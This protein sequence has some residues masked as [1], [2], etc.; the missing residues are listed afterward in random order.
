MNTCYCLSWGGFERDLLEPPV[1]GIGKQQTPLASAGAAPGPLLPGG[2]TRDRQH[3]VFCLLDWGNGRL[4]SGQPGCI[5]SLSGPDAAS[6]SS[7]R[8]HRLSRDGAGTLPS[9]QSRL[10]GLFLLLRVSC[11]LQP[12]G[13][14]TTGI[15]HIKI[16]FQTSF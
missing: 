8:Q 9:Q 14:I 12:Q 10:I 15:K 4:L 11:F 3:E 2:S 7:C 16:Y 6:S 1:C 5:A 13:D